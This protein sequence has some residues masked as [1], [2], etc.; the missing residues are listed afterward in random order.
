MWLAIAVGVC[1]FHTVLLSTSCTFIM[2]LQKFIIKRIASVIESLFRVRLTLYR[3]TRCRV[4]ERPSLPPCPSAQ[5]SS[6]STTSL[7][8]P[9]MRSSPEWFR[10]WGRGPIPPLQMAGPRTPDTRYSNSTPLLLPRVG[11]EEVSLRVTGVRVNIGRSLDHLDPH[12]TG[13]DWSTKKVA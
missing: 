3:G 10:W 6:S 9:R 13:T 1:V 11:R 12:P 7:T 2:V 4:R 8:K 5:P